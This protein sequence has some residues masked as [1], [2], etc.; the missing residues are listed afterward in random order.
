MKA[1][2]PH[3]ADFILAAG[4]PR[5]G[6]TWLYRNISQHPQGNVSRLKETN[7]FSINYYR[8]RGWCDA[9][10]KDTAHA[11]AK[12]D[13]SPFYFLEPD[14]IANVKKENINA[15]VLMILREPN[16]WVRSLYY[17]IKSYTLNMP[18]FEDF[19]KEHVI[20]FDTQPRTI[21]LLDFKFLD[22][23]NELINAFQNNILLINF[24]LIANDPVKLLKEVE[25][26]AGLSSYFND[27]NVI[28]SQI[29]ASHSQ[30]RFINFLS[31]NRYLR[32]IA[33]MLPFTS[34]TDYIKRKLYKENVTQFK[35]IRQQKD[36][37]EKD[38]Y[39]LLAQEKNIDELFP[40]VFKE[41]FFK[42]KD[43]VY[44]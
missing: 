33:N 15:K 34:V 44:L 12:F 11:H 6:S 35:D 19:I 26:F 2:E 20:K 43:I 31:T 28:T 14:F 18:K 27:T 30:F 1:N 38:K 21:N 23:V 4:M 39:E 37:A 36:I 22:R 3:A 7:F 40:P 32:T 10:Y 5:A 16:I 8:G 9:L 13:I 29:N 24:D 41:K 25:N 42:D 17:Q